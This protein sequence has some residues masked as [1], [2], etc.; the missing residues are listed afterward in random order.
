MKPTHGTSTSN[1][2]R[3]SPLT[4]LLIVVALIAFW[5]LVRAERQVGEDGAIIA[6]AEQAL[7]SGKA[8]RSQLAKLKAVSRRHADT[9]RV[10]Q[11]PLQAV[12]IELLS[13]VELRGQVTAWREVARHWERAF[14]AE[15]TRAVIAEARVAELEAHLAAVLTVADCH[16]LGA[17]WLPRCPSRTASFLLGGGTVAALAFIS[18]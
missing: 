16:V 2:I 6:R 1:T 7:A 8:Y 11:A 10:L 12:R 9:A 15:S 5:L 18:R 13:P 3:P 4:L 14:R 17:K